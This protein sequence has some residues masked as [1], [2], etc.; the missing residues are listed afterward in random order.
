MAKFCHKLLKSVAEEMAGCWYE[1]AAHYDHFYKAYPNQGN[2][3][4]RKWGAFIPQARAAL[5]KMLGMPQ[6]SE[7]I[8]EEIFEALCLDRT[9]PAGDHS[10]QARH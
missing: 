7:A 9:V 1:E 2:F 8:K 6:Y 3:I 4:R 5:S 10:I